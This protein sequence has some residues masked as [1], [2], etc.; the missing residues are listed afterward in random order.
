MRYLSYYDV[1]ISKSIS[2]YIRHHVSGRFVH[3]LILNSSG[4]TPNLDQIN[5][6]KA[7]LID[8]L[9]VVLSAKEEVGGGILD[10]GCGSSAG[11]VESQLFRRGFFGIYEPWLCR[12]LHEMGYEPVGVDAGVSNEPFRYVQANLLEKDALEFLPASSV[13]LANVSMLLSSPHLQAL[14]S[15]ESSRANADSI[16]SNLL[17]KSLLNQLRRVLTPNGKVVFYDP[18][19]PLV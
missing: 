1:P 16:S 6:I 15:G 9:E 18:R 8:Q 4:L 7:N 3:N 11:T 17:R 5:L 13:G 12:T 19:H 2:N 14:V 10:C